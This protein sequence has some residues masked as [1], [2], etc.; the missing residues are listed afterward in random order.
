VTARPPGRWRRQERTATARELLGPW[1]VPDGGPVVRTGH[2]AGRAALV[3]GSTQDPAVAD[4]DAA[5]AA[6]V[7][8][9]RRSTGGGAVLVAPHAQVWLDLWIPRDD[10][11]W[12]DDVVRAARFLGR[13]WAT[14]LGTLGAS[15]LAVH[16]G[17]ATKTAWSALVCFAGRGPGEVARADE[18]G[19]AKV[20]G[21]AQRRT[22]A[23]VRLH[24]SAPLRWEPAP[25]LRLLR[26]PGGADASSLDSVA[27]G[28]R[29]V[30]APAHGGLTDAELLTSVEEAVLAA[31]S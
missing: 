16:E 13:A 9:V 11:L 26:V 22:R 7:D 27:V 18:A 1:P 29:E 3:L 20:V 23:G 31:L 25:L 30:V 21:I 15:S 8:V 10:P 24:A 17:G 28:L 14:A 6:A 5:A 2:V 12:D 4:V 19:G